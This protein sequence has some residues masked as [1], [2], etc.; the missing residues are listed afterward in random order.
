MK[1]NKILNKIMQI[2][3]NLKQFKFNKFY[4]FLLNIYKIKY[5]NQKKKLITIQ[6]WSE[7][8]NHDSIKS[9]NCA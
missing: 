5:L 4:T 8:T 6:R 2:I 7:T 3:F 1:N 9:E